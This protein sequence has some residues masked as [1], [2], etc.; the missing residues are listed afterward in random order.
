M[1]L[2]I[3]QEKNIREKMTLFWHNHFS[4][5]TIVISRGIWCYQNNV[6]LRTHA[7]GNF[8]T[9]VKAVTKD[10]G[11]LH[12]LNGYLNTK[13]APD[14]N[15]GRELQELFT[16]GKGADNASPPYTEAD[17]KVAARVLTGW[18]VDGNTNT[19]VFNSN[20]HDNSNK[21]FSTFYNNNIIT[22]LSG[23]TAG[24]TELDNLLSMIFNTPD[25]AL[26]ICRKLYRWFVYYEIDAATE[27][28]I[29]A[30]LADIF[31]NSNYEIAPVMNVLLKSEHFFDVLN[32]GCIIKSPVDNI[33]GLCREFSISFPQPSDITGNYFMWAYLQTNS[34]SFQQEIGDPPSVAGWQAYYQQ[35]Q[36]HE[37]WINSDT[38]TKRNQFSDLLNANG[39]TRQGRTIK[40]DHTVFAASMPNPGDPNRLVEDSVTYLLTIPLSQTSR[41]QIK[42]DILLSGQSTDGYWTSA[43]NTFINNPADMAN[44]SIVKTRLA[45]LYAYLMRLAEY[46]LS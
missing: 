19:T 34:A 10:P 37:L 22:G 7:L 44:T 28:N 18:N 27:A 6:T 16:V 30:P 33:V 32:Q 40:I 31:R 21:Q 36:Y 9:F 41:D 39:Y 23:A 3:N 43:W 26:N 20:R 2:M 17:V 35:P 11:M 14:E 13:T 12:Y 45:S 5:E 29:I 24:D 8:K 15:Y 4:T 42:R 46:Q 38:L 1:G 25:V